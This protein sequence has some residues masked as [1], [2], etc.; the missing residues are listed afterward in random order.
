MFTAPAI[1]TFNL[2]PA[3]PVNSVVQFARMPQ[4]TY[5]VQETQLP[6]VSAQLGRVNGPGLAF[7]QIADHLT[8]DP[9]TVTFMVDEEFRTHRELHSWL[10]GMTGAEDRT[11]RTAQFIEEQ[12]KYIW[13]E[14]KPQNKLTRAAETTAGLT[15]VNGGKLPILRVMFHNLY[16]TALGPVQFSTTTTDTLT[17]LTSTATFEY[18]YYTIVELRR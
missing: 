6:G 11:Y 1:D 3:S 10:A 14:S 5:V 7:R 9:L 2:F 12:N 17:P 8:Y 15:I 13:E 4:L 16:I 18:D